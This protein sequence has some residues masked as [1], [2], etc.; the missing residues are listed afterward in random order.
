MSEVTVQCQ[1]IMDISVVEALYG[2]LE[3]VINEGSSVM[4]K[5]DKVERVDTASLQLLHSFHQEL[6]VHDQTLS[7]N[8]PS[9]ALL[10]AAELIGLKSELGLDGPNT[11]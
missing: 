9:K 10:N 5:A 4:M 11:L 7:W 6:K 8:S 3:K 2:E 1:E